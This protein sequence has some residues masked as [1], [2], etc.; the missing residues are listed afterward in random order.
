MCV[1]TCV[2]EEDACE[3]EWGSMS[4]RRPST[5]WLV[6]HTNR[7]NTTPDQ[8]PDQG[9]HSA[10]TA[11]S[12]LSEKTIPYDKPTA[13]LFSFAC[14]P[15]KGFHPQHPAVCTMLGG[16]SDMWPWLIHRSLLLARFQA[17]GKRVG[18]CV[19]AYRWVYTVHNITYRTISLLQN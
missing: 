2:T 14:L 11:V 15:T 9:Q 18:L 6:L 16:S 12:K 4:S 8:T 13:S 3:T 19:A 10:K 7:C 1:H 17:M 5:P